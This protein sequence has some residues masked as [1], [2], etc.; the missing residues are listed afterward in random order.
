MINARTEHGQ[1]SSPRVR[2]T[3]GE[4]LF[5]VSARGIIPACAGNTYGV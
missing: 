1:G 3:R 2:G 5:R 4:G